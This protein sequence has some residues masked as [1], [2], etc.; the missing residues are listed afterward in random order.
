MPAYGNAQKE[1]TEEKIGGFDFSSNL[2][3]NRDIIKLLGKGCVDNNP[4]YHYR[5][6]Y[7]FP[8]ENVFA[9][10]NIETDDLVVGLQLTKEP[11]ASKRCV[12]TKKLKTFSTGKI[13]AIGDPKDKVI[14]A[15]GQPSKE[16]SQEDDRILYRYYVGRKEGPYMEIKLFKDRVQSIWITVGD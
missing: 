8:S 1:Y 15:Y 7:Y 3:K 4:P 9:A 2:L 12:A 16:V 11:I 6:I 10:F 14:N 13:V 5:R